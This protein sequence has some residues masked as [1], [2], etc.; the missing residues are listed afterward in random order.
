MRDPLFEF[1]N[2][3]VNYMNNWTKR[4]SNDKESNASPQGK[5]TNV[6]CSG[7]GIEPWNLKFEKARFVISAKL[8]RKATPDNNYCGKPLGEKFNSDPKIIQAFEE[9]LNET[10]DN[11]Q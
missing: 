10:M 9:N 6:A 2:R 8:D 5:A 11:K 4:F 1:A 3:T 7:W